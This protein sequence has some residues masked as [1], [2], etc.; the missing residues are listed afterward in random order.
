MA[1][2]A[3]NEWGKG[4][5]ISGEVLDSSGRQVATFESYHR[6]MGFFEFTPQ[7]GERYE[8]RILRPQQAVS[9]SFPLPD[10]RSQGYGLSLVAREEN[11]VIWNIHASCAD[12]QV[13]LI[14]ITHGAVCHDEPLNLRKGV[15]RV[16]VDTRK[17]PAGI[18]VFTLADERGEGLCERLVFLNGTRTLNI[19]VET[20]KIHFPGTQGSIQITTTDEEGNPV[21]A[22]LGVSVVDE[23]LLTFADDKQDHLL[24]YLLMSSGLQGE[25]EEPFF[26]FNKKEPKAGQALDCLLLTHGW[27]RYYRE[28]LIDPHTGGWREEPENSTYIHG[29]LLDQNKQPIGGEKIFLLN[30]NSRTQIAEVVTTPE[31]YFTFIGVDRDPDNYTYMITRRPHAHFEFPKHSPMTLRRPSP[32]PTAQEQRHPEEVPDETEPDGKQAEEAPDRET[33]SEEEALV[34]EPDAEPVPETETSVQQEEPVAA[35]EIPAHEDPPPRDAKLPP[36]LSRSSNR[37]KPYAVRKP[38]FPATRTQ[39]KTW[40][41]SWR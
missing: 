10:V 15:N 6:G 27:R 5:D 31:G 33:E 17:F 3:L 29:R 12:S 20:K 16:E 18:A 25:I 28:I 14:A 8:A 35:Q 34:L 37:P 4:A 38:K 2:E 9:Q 13:R 24:S 23:Q 40:Q 32:T 11:K 39:K 30:G 19:R 36:P 22:L 41:V 1:F 7:A 26:Y 21:P